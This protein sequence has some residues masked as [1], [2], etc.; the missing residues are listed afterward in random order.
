MSVDIEYEKMKA[1]WYNEE[2]GNRHLEDGINC[3]IC[4][5]KGNIAYVDEYG[6]QFVKPCECEKQRTT[7]IRLKNCGIS[8]E[9]L[10]RYTFSN[11]T[12]EN[13]W[14][15]KVKN[16][17]VEYSK[18]IA[19][20]ENNWLYYGGISGAGKTHLCV[21]TFQKL[22]KSN[23]SG[24]YLLW[25]NEFPQ[26]LALEKSTLEENQYKY[27]EK[28]KTLTNVDV[29]YIDDF[30]KLTNNKFSNDNLSLAYKIIN[31]RY[32]NNKIT[33]ISSEYLVSQLNEIDKA[34]C[35]RINEKANFGQ[36][37]FDCG[38]DERKNYRLGDN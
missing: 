4:K 17:F 11:Y 32:I 31:N 12:T 8:R 34:I 13:E 15:K 26:I 30:L 10:E 18:S 27:K 7:F 6:N 29:L 22:I 1:Q 38:E 23:M 33:I 16:I 20:K 36:F 19:N 21:A 37:M 28:I 35:G 9:M 2:E 5:N 3:D 24:Y 14:Q 25:N